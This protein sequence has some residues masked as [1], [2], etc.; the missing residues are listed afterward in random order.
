MEKVYF[1]RTGQQ[2]HGQITRL[3]GHD[4]F[5]NGDGRP[6]YNPSFRQSL[7]L[8]LAYTPGARPDA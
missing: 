5:D 4:V 2:Q 6:A 3:G 8:C 7:P 1:Y